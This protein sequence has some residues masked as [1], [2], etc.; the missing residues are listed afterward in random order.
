MIKY[1]IY[2]RTIIKL[3]E[4]QTCEEEEDVR[5]RVTRYT[6][7][8]TNEKKQKKPFIATIFK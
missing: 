5:I 3:R 4:N 8:F 2:I 1:V 6:V 7:K